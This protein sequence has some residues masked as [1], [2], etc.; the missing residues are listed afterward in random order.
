MR[1]S[2]HNQ[3]KINRFR[4]GKPNGDSV[5]PALEAEDVCPFEI[6]RRGVSEVRRHGASGS[7]LDRDVLHARPAYC[8]K[9][10]TIAPLRLIEDRFNPLTL[11]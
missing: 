11:Y 3:I 8:G 2:V 1:L 10:R 5:F 6:I 9:V 4:R 7:P